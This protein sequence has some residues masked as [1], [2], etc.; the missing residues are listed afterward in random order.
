MNRPICTAVIGLGT[1]GSTH[2]R[3]LASCSQAKLLKCCDVD[4]G[5]ESSSPDGV[6]FTDDLNEVAADPRLEAVVIAT[7]AESH[8]E[9]V[10]RFVARGVAVLCEKPIAASLDDA[11]A[12]VAAS[13]ESEG[14]V[15]IG[16]VMRFDRR[17]KEIHRHMA[18]G[19]LGAP[20]YIAAWLNSD[21]TERDYYAPRTTLARELAVHHLDIF[22]WLTGEIACVYAESTT[23][24]VSGGPLEAALVSTVRFVSGAIGV[25]EV[26]WAQPA[27]RD[28]D[29][30]LSLVGTLGTARANNW[31]CEIV[32]DA[33]PSSLNPV[34]DA[35]LDAVQNEIKTFLRCVRSEE[36]WPL[37]VADA[38]AALAASLA[39]ERSLKRHAPVEVASA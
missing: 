15:F 17:Y 8:R 37:R 19:S 39:L 31:G 29:A 26:S 10:E 3:I 38:R 9:I 4:P 6:P 23:L 25:L 18:N 36:S 27:Q 1:M 28:V 22:R 33:S 34:P 7:P 24:P 32:T 21:T 14:R 12:I 16:H 20:I 2:A 30:G 13:E 11:D 35:S 5:R